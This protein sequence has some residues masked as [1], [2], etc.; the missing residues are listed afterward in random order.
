VCVLPRL[1]RCSAPAAQLLHWHRHRGC[2][3]QSIQLVCVF[4]CLC[5]PQGLCTRYT[6]C[7]AFTL[8]L[9]LCK[10]TARKL[11]WVSLSAA[12]L[13]EGVSWVA[14]QV[15]CVC[16]LVCRVGQDRIYPPYVALYLV[17]SLPKAPCIHRINMVL[18]SP[19]NMG[20]GRIARNGIAACAHTADPTRM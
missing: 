8:A 11:W 3:F 5:A 4:M 15:V 2:L 19:R 9:S 12:G 13:W 14:G 10:V 20:N 1:C 16:A 7:S 18:A 6:C 17:K